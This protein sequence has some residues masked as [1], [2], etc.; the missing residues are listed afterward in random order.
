[1]RSAPLVDPQ[2][3][4][5]VLIC[6]S[7]HQ[8]PQ[9]QKM[10]QRLRKSHPGAKEPV[11]DLIYYSVTVTIQDNNE[12]ALQPVPADTSSIT[13]PNILIPHV[14]PIP[15]PC[16][17]SQKLFAK[18]AQKLV[19]RVAKEV[20]TKRNNTPRNKRYCK[21]CKLGC[22]SAKKAQDRLKFRTHSKAEQKNVLISIV[23]HAS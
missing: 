16:P 6:P 11:I 22:N 20:R 10:D 4:E 23:S 3:L 12:P 15:P 5:I 14:A 19:D 8:A 2:S 9:D 17:K 21:T 13:L 1:M 7:V 18:K